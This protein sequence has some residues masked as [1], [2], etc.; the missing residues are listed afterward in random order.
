MRT[1]ALMSLVLSMIIGLSLASCS[2]SNYSPANSSTDDKSTSQLLLQVSLR[3]QQLTDPIPDRLAQMQA[4]G[5]STSDLEIQRIYIYVKEPLTQT[6]IGE[7]EALGITVY[8]NSWIPPAGSNPDGF[9]L[10]NLPIDKLDALAAKEYIIRL[11]TAET[12]LSP[13]SEVPNGELK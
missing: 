12:I 5:M 11:D 9:Y 7:L 1:I 4:Q 2:S 13:Q 3:R 10:T 6:Q 8:L